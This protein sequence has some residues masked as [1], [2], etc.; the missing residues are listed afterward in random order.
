[1]NGSLRR[2]A[3]F[4]E[5]IVFTIVVPG[6][7][8]FW[9]P[10]MILDSSRLVILR[11]WSVSQYVALV[12]LTAGALMYLRCLWE[13]AARGRGIPAPIDH[14]KQLVV[15]G[16]YRYVRNPM[17]VGVLLFLLGEALFLQYLGF[18]W[19]TIGWFVFV[20]LA[21]VLYE[22]PNLRRKFGD[23]YVH[24]ASAVHRWMPGRAYS[25]W[26]RQ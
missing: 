3:L 20:N 25:D 18:L 14:P 13:F 6:T 7:V 24:Y 21:I 15:T 26:Q 2:F 10:G 9:L 11:P 16:L 1:M 17:Y 12:L 8:A 19:Y 5:T 4:L 22:E 23:S